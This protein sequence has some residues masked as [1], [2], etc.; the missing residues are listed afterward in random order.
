[1]ILNP[2]ESQRL[3]FIRTI[4]V[5]LI[6]I[7]HISK[8]YEMNLG[9]WT[10]TGVQVFLVISGFLSGQKEIYNW[11]DWFRCRFRRLIPSYY[12][13]LI[14]TA[15][16][17]WFF[18][19]INIVDTRFIAH[20]ST[21]HFLLF[22][23]CPIWGGHLWY[24]TAIVVCYCIFPFLY[25]TKEMYFPYFLFFI[26]VAV[27]FALILVCYKY[28]AVIPYRLS[29]DIYS[30]IAGFA[31]AKIFATKPAGYL[32]PLSIF[33][34]FL[35]IAL[36][37]T[38]ILNNY[39]NQLFIKELIFVIAPWIKFSLGISIFFLFYSPVFNKLSYINIVNFIDKYS[40]E[41]YLSHKNFILGPL[42]LLHMTQIRSFNIVIALFLS[43]TLAVFIQ[44]ITIKIVR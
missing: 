14:I 37:E 39:W 20:F 34:S 5:W 28:K 44:K 4:A 27:P 10:N 2:D 26:F 42:S 43:I 17:Y 38:A 9:Q 19:H 12:T 36:K 18:L 16:G 29:A 25:R 33:M 24:I 1:M 22:P 41:I 23:G 21:I 31:I 8:E 7:T 15:V 32:T 11:N 30:F 3:K 6:I 13:I 35:L 40:Y